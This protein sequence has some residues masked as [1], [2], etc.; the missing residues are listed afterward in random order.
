LKPKDRVESALIL[1]DN[2]YIREENYMSAFDIC[3][4]FLILSGSFA[5]ICLGILLLKSSQVLKDVSA[6]TKEVEVTIDKVNKTVDDVN[7]KMDQMNAPVE[8]VN[9]VFT[10]RSQNPG[11]L[12]TILGLKSFFKKK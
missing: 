5:L 4:A 2:I 3:L 1:C 6:L 10:K 7:Y 11:I 9:R 12:G 8:F